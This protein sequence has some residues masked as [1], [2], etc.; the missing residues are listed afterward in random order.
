MKQLL[1][2][3]EKAELEGKCGGSFGSYGWSGEAPPRIYETMKNIYK[4]NMAVT[5]CA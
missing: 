2:I 4:M 3:A 5:A 1:F